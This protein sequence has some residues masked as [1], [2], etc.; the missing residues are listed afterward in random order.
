MAEAA[1]LERRKR[2]GTGSCWRRC[3]D[4][5]SATHGTGCKQTSGTRRLHRRGFSSRGVN[6]TRSRL[7]LLL[8]IGFAVAPCPLTA[9]ITG[10]LAELEECA[11]LVDE[12]TEVV[13]TWS[14]QAEITEETILGDKTTR[15]T[16]AVEFLYKANG[17]QVRYSY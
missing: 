13:K 10:S 1:L 7:T 5:N 14:G 12:N 2:I 11:K 9:E 6:M 3:W 17:H 4:E 15:R 8:L 16:T